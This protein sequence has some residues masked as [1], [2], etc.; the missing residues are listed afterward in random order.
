MFSGM[1]NY[2]IG[3]H[4]RYTVDSILYPIRW[5][6]TAGNRNP[7]FILPFYL[8]AF[9]LLFRTFKVDKWISMTGAFATALSSYFFVIIAA[10][11]NGK[12]YSITWM[13]LVV[14]GFIL[15]YRKQYD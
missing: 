5:M 2:Q 1:P 11:H 10:A 14:V 13:T 9:F 6:M 3:G 4:R 15:T 12:C 7:L 8:L